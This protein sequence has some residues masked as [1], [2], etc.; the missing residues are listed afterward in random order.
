MSLLKRRLRILLLIF[1]QT[2]RGTYQRAYYFS[3]TL[4]R[5]GH[6]VTLMVTS[7]RARFCMRQ[8]PLDGFQLVECPDLLPASLRSGWDV[9]NTARRMLWLLGRRFDI[10]HAIEARP[11]VL[12]PALLA[13]RRGAQLVMDWCDWFGRG[14]SVEER[15]AGWM[16]AL[17]RP[18]DT[19]FEERFRTR[20]NQTLVITPFLKERAV[21]LGVQPE[22]ISV[23]RNGCDAEVEPL[24]QSIARQV[25]GLPANVPLIGYL[26]SCYTRDA[27]LMA[28]ALNRVINIMPAARLV[29]IGYFNRDIESLVY[30]PRSIIRTGH[31]THDAL[32]RYLAACD[33]CWLPLRDS[34]A[35]RGR[36]P[37][38]LN[39]YMVVSRPVVSTGIGELSKLIPQ[40]Q[41]GVIA[42]DEPDDFAAQ[43]LTLLSD[44]RRRASM[45]QAAR[46]AAETVMNWERMVDD[47]EGAYQRALAAR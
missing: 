25:V 46:R 40:L 10:V 4:A 37:G 3:R 18:I 20:A 45:G 44:P 2:G 7:P 22:T 1:N 28:L 38:K 36:W 42:R 5:R 47:L 9:W 24:K 15:P 13:Q 19:F 41:M 16:R 34:G 14:G 26:G 31:V 17:I 11:V 32:F 21:A 6:Q 27:E 12:L 35:N 39:D 33:V 8:F 29:L 43:T 23:I 30:N